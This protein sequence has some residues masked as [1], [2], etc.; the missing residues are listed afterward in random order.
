[1]I[2]LMAST[3]LQNDCQKQAMR[4]GNGIGLVDQDGN[5]KEL[6]ELSL[7]LNQK[8]RLEAG[9][10]VITTTSSTARTWHQIT[11]S[12]V[13][14]SASVTQSLLSPS[15]LGCVFSISR[16][17]SLCPPAAAKSVRDGSRNYFNRF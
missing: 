4:N 7:N 12:G 13:H 5:G 8:L 14:S 17:S 11:E 2:V 6:M 15:I 10:G 3:C 1:M 9:K 16:W